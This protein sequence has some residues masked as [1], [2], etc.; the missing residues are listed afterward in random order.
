MK[1]KNKHKKNIGL[2]IAVAGAAAGAVVAGVAAYRRSKSEQV[3]H[4]AELRAMSELDDM[5]AENEAACADC[6][7]ADTCTAEEECCDAA[8]EQMSIEVEDEAPEAEEPADKTEILETEDDDD[9]NDVEAE[10]PADTE[11]ESDEEPEEET[12]D[13]DSDPSDDEDED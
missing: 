5:N 9:D 1:S 2:G 4:E 13:D 3:Y 7:C 10:V 6:D 11:V 12:A 8:G